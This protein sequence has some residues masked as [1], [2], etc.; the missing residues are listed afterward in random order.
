M[1]EFPD[2]PRSAGESRT[3]EGQHGAQAH[4]D[5]E[6]EAWLRRELAFLYRVE[7][8][9]LRR[10]RM[11]QEA[12]RA[13]AVALILAMFA[14]CWY[15]AALSAGNS[16]SKACPAKSA[17]AVSAGAHAGSGSGSTAAS[18]ASSHPGGAKAAG[19]T[20]SGCAA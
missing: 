10:A 15:L 12:W 14:C 16:S 5:R 2:E 7:R 18:A 20:T 4:A 13:A 17:T 3:P 11:R 9:I 19:A 8:R 6:T 1:M